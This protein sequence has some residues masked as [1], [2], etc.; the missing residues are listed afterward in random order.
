MITHL[1]PG[2]D[3]TWIDPD[4]G[5]MVGKPLLNAPG[6]YIS[7]DQGIVTGFPEPETPLLV[8]SNIGRVSFVP[9]NQL[10][11]CHTAPTTNRT[12]DRNHR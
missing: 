2:D 1:H 3:V 11:P 9:Y 8:I 6:R 10:K 12:T 7:M 4:F 5:A